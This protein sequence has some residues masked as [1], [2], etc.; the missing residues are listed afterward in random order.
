MDLILKESIDVIKKHFPAVG[1]AM[2]YQT[3]EEV[4][5]FFILSLKKLR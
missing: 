5:S 3:L 2:L 1:D 4:I